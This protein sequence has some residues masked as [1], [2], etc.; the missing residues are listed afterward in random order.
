MTPP[1]ALLREAEDA[2]TPDQAAKAVSTSWTLGLSLDRRG[3]SVFGRSLSRPGGRVGNLKLE[4][5]VM[6]KEELAELQ[7][8]IEASFIRSNVL[9]V[10]EAE[11]HAALAVTHIKNALARAAAKQEA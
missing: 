5:N 11:G 10:E 9:S 3:T 6:T 8:T 4:R 2:A 7:Q 1:L